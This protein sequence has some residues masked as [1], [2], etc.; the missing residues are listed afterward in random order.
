MQGIITC[1]FF[2]T[3]NKEQGMKVSVARA[4][5]DEITKR[6]IV[7]TVLPIASN[8]V[9]RKRLETFEETGRI[10]LLYDDDVASLVSDVEIHSD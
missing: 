8:D 3:F 1:P 5:V 6:G 2:S 10:V 4:L 7:P 9:W